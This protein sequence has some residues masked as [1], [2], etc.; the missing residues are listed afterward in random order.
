MIDGY[1]LELESIG[2][3]K[4]ESREKQISN[5]FPVVYVELYHNNREELFPTFQRRLF[6]SPH[7]MAV[8]IATPT[9]ARVAFF[10]KELINEVKTWTELY[11]LLNKNYDK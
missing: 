6:H 3:R 7:R 8:L 11:S 10:K 9:Y 2:F 4:K 5:A 1:I